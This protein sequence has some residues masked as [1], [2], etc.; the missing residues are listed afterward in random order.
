MTQDTVAVMYQIRDVIKDT[1]PEN[2]R[3]F[4]SDDWMASNAQMYRANEAPIAV[5]AFL[6]N[7]DDSEVAVPKHLLEQLLSAA[8]PLI[9][10]GEVSEEKFGAMS[11]RLRS[12]AKSDQAILH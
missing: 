10:G 7:L 11:E 8:K 6:S 9:V 3:Y 5:S 1:V 2:M 4:I 12:N